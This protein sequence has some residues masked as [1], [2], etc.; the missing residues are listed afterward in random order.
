MS[1]SIFLSLVQQNFL[2]HQFAK[3]DDLEQKVKALRQ[4]LDPK[5][6]TAEDNSYSLFTK[7]SYNL[8]QLVLGQVLEQL[9]THIKQ[10]TIIPDG[11]LSYV[12]FE[13]LLTEP[14][15]AEIA[16]YREVAYLLKQYQ[17][18]YAYAAALITNRVASLNKPSH[19][20]V[21]AF[22][23]S[24]DQ[25]VTDSVELQQLGQFR[26]QVTALVWN[27]KEV[28]RIA[29]YLPTEYFTAQ[30]ATESKFREIASQY[31]IIHLAMH[32]LVDD[33]NPMQSRLVFTQ[34][35]SGKDDRYLNAYE[36]YNMDL[37]ADLAILSACNT[38]Y[39][40]YV[41]GEG[42]MS[43]G[44]AFA[45]AGCPSVV[46]SHWSVDD[47]ATSELMQ[48]FYQGLAD[49]LSK[50]EAM[51]KAKLSY[52]ET[53]GP[54][55][56]NPIYWGSFVVIGDDA[57]VTSSSLWYWVLGIVVGLGLTLVVL[58]SMRATKK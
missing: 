20:G 24:Y 4:G 48:V 35:N 47:Q 17:I 36:L 18:N 26:D 56:A 21:L 42:M 52:L 12:P 53:T 40:K 7:A 41:R 25:A 55:E 9:P 3:T 29:A 39:G 49:G 32:A 5:N 34:N 54:R 31:R 8:Q 37:N 23:P 30:D 15:N 10:L 57:P 13:V 43:L 58:R 45:F 28:E 6:Q 51:R 11:I 22:A 50:S 38:G 44:R 19:D 27:T 2:I 14:A 1:K 16:D 33:D 46:I